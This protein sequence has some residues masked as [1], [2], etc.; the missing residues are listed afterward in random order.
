MNNEK[1]WKITYSNII[2]LIGV[3]HPAFNEPQERFDNRV[4]DWI[5]FYQQH[6]FIP[7]GAI[8]I[9]GM[10]VDGHH[11]LLAT[12]K[13]GIPYSCNIVY[14]GDNIWCMTGQIAIVK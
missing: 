10:M 14:S 9:N 13:L 6:K 7:S 1:S 3:F 8:T 2:E 11:R 12:R 4:N 5:N